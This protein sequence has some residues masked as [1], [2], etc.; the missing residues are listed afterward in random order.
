MCAVASVTM[1]AYWA[2]PTMQ[3]LLRVLLATLIAVPSTAIV[4]IAMFV[5]PPKIALCFC[6]VGMGLFKL[7]HTTKRPIVLAIGGIV[8]FGSVFSWAVRQ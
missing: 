5:V 3:P 1:E 4:A 8:M 6:V 7:G 2:E